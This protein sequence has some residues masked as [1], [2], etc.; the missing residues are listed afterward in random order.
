MNTA[1]APAT[2]KPEL[3]CP[4]GS[5]RALHLAIDA[6]ADAVYMGLKDATNARNFAG[7]NFDLAATREGIAYA[8]AR[9][10]KVLM[11]LNTFADARDIR[12]WQRA[13]DSAAQLGI[14]A[15]ILADIAVLAWAERA[16][17]QLRLH[18]SVQASATNHEAIEFYRARYRIARAVLPRVLSVSQVAHLVRHS[19]VEIE[20]FGFGSLCVMAE[21]RCHLSSY[22]TGQSPNNFGACSPAAFVRWVDRADHGVDVRLNGIQINRYAPEEAR[23]YPTLCKGRFQVNDRIDYAIE[24]PTSL[25]TLPILPELIAAGVAAI[26]IEGRQRSPAYVEQV[27]RTW[28]AAIDAA[29]AAPA[30]FA[31]R[32]EWTAALGRL[33][34]GQQHTLGAYSRPWK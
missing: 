2:R 11:A 16:H 12:P 18:L 32:P 22:A 6:G 30:R 26:K 1:A 15:L 3:V 19:K 14:D 8:H 13:V 17:P 29:A 4:A 27:T 10:R 34:E 9:G 23:A 28:R 24:E 25:N 20:V 5:L 31:P 7:L 33:A 21:G